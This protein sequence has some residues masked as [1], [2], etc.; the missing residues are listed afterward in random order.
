MTNQQH[1]S[2]LKGLVTRGPPVVST[3]RSIWVCPITPIKS[4]DRLILMFGF[5]PQERAWNRC[6]RNSFF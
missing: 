3:G 5:R 1:P 4:P 6:L 2:A